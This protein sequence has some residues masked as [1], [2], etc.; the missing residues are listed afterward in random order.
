MYLFSG[1]WDV[2][3]GLKWVNKYIPAFGGD[4]S[5]ITVAGWDAGAVAVGLLSISPLSRG[6]YARQIMQSG[7]P[8][9]RRFDNNAQDLLY[10]EQLLKSFQCYKKYDYKTKK[11]VK[12]TPEEMVNCLKKRK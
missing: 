9:I 4:S 1:V 7:S 5:R 8:V 11:Y 2:L 6:L 12:R 10:S 3:E